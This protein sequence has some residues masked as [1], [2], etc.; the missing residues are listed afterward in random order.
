MLKY[1]SNLASGSGS[2]P[3][4]KTYREDS[5]KRSKRFDLA[6]MD[7]NNVYSNNHARKASKGS[8][9][10]RNKASSIG[11]LEP[12]TNKNNTRSGHGPTVPL[13]I[14]NTLDPPRSNSTLNK[15][16]KKNLVQHRAL[17]S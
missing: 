11:R 13:H 12:L 15:V 1:K 10:G 7:S 8:I 9:T 3:S 6:S 17:G 2:L 14:F 16:Q 4:I 5:S